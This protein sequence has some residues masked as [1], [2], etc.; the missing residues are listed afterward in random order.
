MNLMHLALTIFILFVVR[1][2]V[3]RSERRLHVLWPES[4]WENW[5]TYPSRGTLMN[6]FDFR[7]HLSRVKLYYKLQH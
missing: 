2:Q 1:W 3:A 7:S 5:Q 6:I 4:I